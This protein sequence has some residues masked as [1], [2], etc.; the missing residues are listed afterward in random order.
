MAYLF[1][2]RKK[3]EVTKPDE[4]HDRVLKQIVSA[5]LRLQTGWALWMGK[6]TQHLSRRT[7]LLLLV[8]FIG[9]AGGYSIYLIGQSFSGIQTNAFSVTPIKKPGFVRQTGETASPT[10]MNIDKPDYQRIVRFR[11]YMDS[12]TRSPAGKAV[13]DSILPSRPGLLDSARFIEE[14]YQSQTK[15]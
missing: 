7:L 3:T 11:G 6:R 1:K 10:D 9:F 8:A 13:Y 12:L 15:K 2:R 14:I 4:D 5:C